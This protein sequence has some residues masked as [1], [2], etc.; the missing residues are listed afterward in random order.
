MSSPSSPDKGPQ[1]NPGSPHSSTQSDVFGPDYANP[2][3]SS[4]PRVTFSIAVT[5]Y[6][7]KSKTVKGKTTVSKKAE[8]SKSKELVFEL[9]GS[10]YLDFL[11]AVLEKHGLSK[12]KVSDSAVFPFSYYYKGRPKSNALVVDTH[13]DFNNLVKKACDESL[14]AI[15]IMVD[16]EEVE[17]HCHWRKRKGSHRLHGSDDERSFSDSSSESDNAHDGDLDNTHGR[18]TEDSLSTEECIIA[19]IRQKLVKKYPSPL[20]SNAE[21]T[22]LYPDGHALP[23]L[24]GL[25]FFK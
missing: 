22:Y 14:R 12:Y 10:R 2:A 13:S 3:P 4:H 6:I 9:R 16:M 15:N 8:K 11:K 20:G 5:C 21:A 7:E 23:S 18:L 1:S 17:R 19:E 25:H 24:L